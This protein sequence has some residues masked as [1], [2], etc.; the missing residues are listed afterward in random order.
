MKAQAMVRTVIACFVIWMAGSSGALAQTNVHYE[1]GSDCQPGFGTV[2]QVGYGEPGI[3]NLSTTSEAR[4]FCPVD[5]S[6]FRNNVW[7]ATTVVY[8]SLNYV[9]NSNAVPFWCYMWA[10]ENDGSA[11]WSSKKY[12][13]S[14]SGG[15]G[16]YDSTTEFVGSYRIDWSNPFGEGRYFNEPTIGYSCNIPRVAGGFGASWV[17]SYYTFTQPSP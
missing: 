2:G 12:T 17:E 5:R 8:G 7:P 10:T 1:H 6:E 13:C 11:T 4:V 15:Q 3:G 14:P 16:C 9:D